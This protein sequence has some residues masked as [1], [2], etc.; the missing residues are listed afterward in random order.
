MSLSLC[1]QH[2]MCAA[3]LLGQAGGLTLRG[4]QRLHG[5]GPLPQC[6]L[7]VLPR[8]GCLHQPHPR[9][10][11]SDLPYIGRHAQQGHDH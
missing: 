10:L 6:S 2:G 5:L 1:G 8:L 11:L 7:S 3:Y 9:T 4:A